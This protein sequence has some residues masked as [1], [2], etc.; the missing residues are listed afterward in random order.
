MIHPEFRFA[1]RT[2]WPMTLEDIRLEQERLEKLY[3][4]HLR[5]TC[6]ASPAR[7]ART[8]SCSRRHVYRLLKR[9]GLA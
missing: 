1:V 8:L 2:S 6:K 7:I 3:L 4:L 5:E 9:H